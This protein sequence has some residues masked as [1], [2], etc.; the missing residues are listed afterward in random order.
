MHENLKLLNK[1]VLLVFS[2][3]TLWRQKLCVL[4]NVYS[5]KHGCNG[6]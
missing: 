4:E 2:L 5:P 1:T 6:N 3:H